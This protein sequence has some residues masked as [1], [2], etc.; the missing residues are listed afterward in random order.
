MRDPSYQVIW[1]KED[2]SLVRK[3]ASRVVG[4]KWEIVK[5]CIRVIEEN[6]VVVKEMKLKERVKEKVSWSAENERNFEELKLRNIRFL[7]LKES[8]MKEND[9]LNIFENF[10][11]RKGLNRVKGN[12]ERDIEKEIEK[13][14]I[15]LKEIQ[16]NKKTAKSK[17]KKIELFNYC[18]ERLFS[19]LDSWKETP[20]TENETAFKKLKEKAKKERIVEAMGRRRL[21]ERILE[22]KKKEGRPHL[23]EDDPG[24]FTQDE[25]FV[26]ARQSL[27]LSSSVLVDIE[28]KTMTLPNRLEDYMKMAKKKTPRKTTPLKR[29]RRGP[30]VNIPVAKLNAENTEFMS[31]PNVK[32]LAERLNQSQQSHLT[33]AKVRGQLSQNIITKPQYVYGSGVQTPCDQLLTGPTNQWENRSGISLGSRWQIGQSD[34]TVEQTDVQIKQIGDIRKDRICPPVSPRK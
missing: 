21:S 30:G 25:I 18:K 29:L 28:D 11:E 4:R 3:T 26:V 34:Q 12:W 2:D 10:C 32:Y 20:G 24:T 27:S 16:L 6:C 19:L 23:L 33:P 7:N 14:E 8:K 31:G 22:D 13:K 9:G 5:V 17:R 1:T 15:E